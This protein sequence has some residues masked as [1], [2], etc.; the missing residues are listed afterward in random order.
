M[1]ISVITTGWFAAGGPGP[2]GYQGGRLA[3]A[4]EPVAA[5]APVT[6]DCQQAKGPV[7]V[8]RFV[9]GPADVMFVRQLTGPA[10]QEPLFG[11][12]LPHGRLDLG[13][14][15]RVRGQ[16]QGEEQFAGEHGSAGSQTIG[17]GKRAPRVQIT[18]LAFGAPIASWAG[19]RQ[20]VQAAGLAGIFSR[21]PPMSA[22]NSSFPPSAATYVASASTVATSPRSICDTLPGLTPM[23]SASPACVNPSRFRSSAS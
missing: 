1:R 13:T 4:G 18:S 16:E 22:T 15:Y 21:C 2:Q 19:L 11:D 3:G 10:F 17:D 12:R 6:A 7:Q 23:I 14:G 20:Q 8:A 9:D 5:V